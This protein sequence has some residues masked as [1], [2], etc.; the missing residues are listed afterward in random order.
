MLCADYQTYIDSQAEVDHAYRDS[1]HWSRMSI[2]NV[3]RI[4]KFSSDRSIRDYCRD[5]WN[6][7]P[8]QTKQPAEEQLPPDALHKLIGAEKTQSVTRG[9]VH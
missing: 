5:I 1:H 2:L 4:G 8:G 9:E 6:I 3:A 7:E